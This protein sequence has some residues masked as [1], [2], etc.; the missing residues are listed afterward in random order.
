MMSLETAKSISNFL[1]SNQI[2]SVNL[3]GGEFFLNKNWYE[4]I[5]LITDGLENV[6][7]VTTG[8]WVK[9]NY[10]KQ[11]LLLLKEKLG[12]VLWIAISNDKWHTNKNIVEAEEFLKENGFIYHVETKEEGDDSSIVPIGR[13]DGEYSFYGM[14]GCYCHNPKNMY[15]FLIN[16]KGVIYKCGFGVWDY[17]SVQEYEEGGF[18]KKFKELNKKFYHIFITSCMSCIRMAKSSHAL[19]LHDK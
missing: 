4:I 17:A 9:D 7:L 6:R 16:E 2:Y 19:D 14:F 15:S 5:L 3:M 10:T 12:D 18:R 1:K 11:K 13:A 8:D